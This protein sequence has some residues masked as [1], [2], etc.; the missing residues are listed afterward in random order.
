VQWGLARALHVGQAVRPLLQRGKQGF[1]L[2][3]DWAAIICNT[4]IIFVTANPNYEDPP[5]NAAS[6]MVAETRAIPAA[7]H[8][9]A[10]RSSKGMPRVAGC[11]SPTCQRP[12]PCWAKR[13]FL[14]Q[15]KGL[16]QDYIWVRFL[17]NSEGGL[18]SKTA[19]SML[20]SYAKPAERQ[21]QRQDFCASLSIL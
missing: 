20:E 17:K 6:K 2:Q 19:Q 7:R 14:F 21:C 4:T 18:S 10:W 13:D 15:E 9:Q 11:Y 12:P 8:L 16:Y 1:C 3:A 5:G